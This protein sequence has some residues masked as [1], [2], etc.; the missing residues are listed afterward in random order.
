MMFE[1]SMKVV[2]IGVLIFTFLSFKMGFRGRQTKERR[3]EVEKRK[4]KRVK[5]KR[6]ETRRKEDR[7]WHTREQT[8]HSE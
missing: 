5:E 6:S 7:C 8:Q 2:Y 4:R 1:S 3:G